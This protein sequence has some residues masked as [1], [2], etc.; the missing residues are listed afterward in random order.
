MVYRE[1]LVPRLEVL[2]GPHGHGAAQHGVGGVGPVLSV[3][4]R[5][6]VSLVKIR[7]MKITAK[8]R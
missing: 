5:T 3:G 6:V 1:H 4:P 8:F 7:N 2:G